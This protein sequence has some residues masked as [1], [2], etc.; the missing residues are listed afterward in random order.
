MVLV[1]AQ[2]LLTGDGTT[3]VIQADLRDPDG[4]L[5]HA[6][7]R[8]LIDFGQPVG[9]MER[10]SVGAAKSPRSWRIGPLARRTLDEPHAVSPGSH[11]QPSKR[12]PAPADSAL[13]WPNSVGRTV[14]GRS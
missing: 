5:G 14:T 12:S 3:S 2:D 4:L 8:R 9:L 10:V 13:M 6:D 7:L 11:R 1:T